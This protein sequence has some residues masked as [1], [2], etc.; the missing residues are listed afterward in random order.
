MDPKKMLKKNFRIIGQDDDDN[1]NYSMIIN[2][3]FESINT[4]FLIIFHELSF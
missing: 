4:T 2:P 1:N 3:I